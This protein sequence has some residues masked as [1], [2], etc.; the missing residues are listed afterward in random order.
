MLK[1]DNRKTEKHT[2]KKGERKKGIK[3][4]KV[5]NRSFVHLILPD[6]MMFKF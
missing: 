4:K 3:E 2:R 6:V 1:R 5:D